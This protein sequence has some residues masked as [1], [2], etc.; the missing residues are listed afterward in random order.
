MENQSLELA[1]GRLVEGVEGLVFDGAFLPTGEGKSLAHY[2]TSVAAFARA[3]WYLRECSLGLR[4]RASRSVIVANMGRVTIENRVCFH[5]GPMPAYLIVHPGGELVI[6]AQTMVSYGVSINCSG[7]IEIGPECR[8]GTEVMIMDS[9]RHRLEPGRRI[10]GPAPEPVRLGRNVW[11]GARVMVKPGVTIG[12]NAVVAAG[13]I[14]TRDVEA[15]A[16]YAGVPA[17][18]VRYL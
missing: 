3:S 4:V 16:V 15:N 8:L 7:R 2:L 6:G 18:R 11:L 17:R 1:G 9:H 13:S 14:V 10:E 12:D 5:K